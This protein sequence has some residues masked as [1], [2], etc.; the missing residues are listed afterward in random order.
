MHDTDLATIENR[1]HALEDRIAKTA[2]RSK[3]RQTLTVAVMA[4]LLVGAF[5]Y[6][7]FLSTSITTAADA[8]T[9][10]QLVADQIEP[11]LQQAPAQL[12]ESLKAQ[13]P[14]VVDSSEKIILDALPEALDQAD[15]FI[16]S[17]FEKEFQEIERKAYDVIHDGFNDVIAQAK[18]KKID[19]EKDGELEEAVGKIAPNLRQMIESIIEENMDEFKSGTNEISAYISRLSTDKDLTDHEKAH[20]E[21]MISGIALIRKME[22]DP[23]RSPISGIMRGDLPDNQKPSSTTDQ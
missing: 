5:F 13:A 19:L 2:A 8:P 21:I 4:C 14:I 20:R 3:S 22:N 23:S 7:R 16:I 15:E 17:F 9:L 18:E 6:L 1:L 12:T 11:R 10:V